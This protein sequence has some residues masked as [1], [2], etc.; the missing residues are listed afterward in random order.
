MIKLE[1]ALKTKPQQQ[2]QEK[3]FLV[4]DGPKREWFPVKAKNFEEAIKKARGWG[5]D[6]YYIVEENQATKVQVEE[7]LWKNVKR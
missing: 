5:Y 1:T 6:P 3:S 4:L 2:T 7:K